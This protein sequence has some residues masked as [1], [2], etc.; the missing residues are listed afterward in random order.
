MLSQ[1][2]ALIFV[3]RDITHFI[4]SEKHHAYMNYVYDYVRVYHEG[5]MCI[6]VYIL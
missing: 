6:N 3:T 1:S 4:V 5:R 2:R